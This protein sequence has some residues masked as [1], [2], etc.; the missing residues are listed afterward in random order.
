MTGLTLILGIHIHPNLRLILIIDTYALPD[1]IPV[2]HPECFRQNTDY[3]SMK[4][5]T[6]SLSLLLITAMCSCTGSDTW[7]MSAEIENAI[8]KTSFPADTFN[9]VDFG[10]VADDTSF[11]NTEAIKAAILKCH[12]E[13]GGVVLVPPRRLDDR[14]GNPAE[15]C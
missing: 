12:D 6:L 11:L 5:I 13:G 4:R 3:Q 2:T 10:A 1:K 14:A 8:V 15:Q 7:K 9:I